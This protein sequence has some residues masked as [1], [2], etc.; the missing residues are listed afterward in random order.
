MHCVMARG[1][2]LRADGRLPCYC[3]AGETVTLG[4][5]N[6]RAMPEDFFDAVFGGPGFAHVRRCMA[7]GK[8]P[9]PG[10]CEQCTYLE[11]LTPTP[12]LDSGLAPGL[13]PGHA[14]EP[15]LEWL[16]L[17]PSYACNLDCRWCHGQDRAAAAGSLLLPGRAVER[18][19]RSFAD[20][21]WRLGKGNIC[22]VGEPTLNPEVWGMVATLK[23][24]MGGDILMST[25]GNGPFHPDIV[26][27][28]L[29]TIK[30]A[31]DAASPEIYGRYRRHGSLEKVL[32]FTARVASQRG[33]GTRPRIV[34]QYIMFDYNDS[35]AELLHYQRMAQDHGVDRL[36]IVYTRCTRYSRRSPEDFPMAFKD[37][38]FFPI[39][40]DSLLSLAEAAARLEAL[41]IRDGRDDAPGL[42]ALARHIFHRLLLGVERYVDLLAF[43]R[44]LQ[45]V[46]Q[47]DLA[48]LSEEEFQGFRR[49]LGVLFHR[50][51][52]HYDS[53]GD[54]PQAQAYVRFMQQ[55]RLEGGPLP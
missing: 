25:N 26:S 54:A 36:R 10:V 51:A 16:H 20:R 14:Q 30:I 33:A 29:D 12:F 13:A 37:I 9:F 17:E 5:V 39:K 32:R 28:G 4:Q 38:Q 53:Q 45:P 46:G 31:A 11:A 19:A 49:L 50:L 44:V 47:G 48:A 7:E 43:S 2:Y 3:S 21:G 22:G 41:P 23:E 42:M 18:I 34:W 55:T 40:D 27:C 52:R 24:R 8:A 6:P 1:L 15:V 35:D